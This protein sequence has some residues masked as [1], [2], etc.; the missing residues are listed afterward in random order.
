MLF[1]SLFATDSATARRVREAERG[2]ARS[3]PRHVAVEEL[4]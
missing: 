3:L 1:R 4:P 2:F